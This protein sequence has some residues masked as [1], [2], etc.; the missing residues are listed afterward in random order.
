MLIIG[1]GKL[2]CEITDKKSNTSQCLDIINLHLLNKI[3][4]IDVVDLSKENVFSFDA[5]IN[6]NQKWW[7]KAYM[8]I[9]NNYKNRFKILESLIKKLKGKIGN[10]YTILEL[11]M[12]YKFFTGNDIDYNVCNCSN[13]KTLK[14]Y[15][16]L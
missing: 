12:F 7:L 5:T 10:C 16:K 6:L 2:Y 11:C 9:G 1:N 13:K 4:T 15:I 8:K 3:E 14:L